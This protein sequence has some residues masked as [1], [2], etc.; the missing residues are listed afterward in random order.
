MVASWEPGTQYNIGDVVEYQGHRYKIIQP[1]R[2]Q[3]DW[4]PDVTPAL[5]GR[6]PDNTWGDEKQGGGGY[7]PSYDQPPA[8]QPY[9][10]SRPPM[11]QQPSGNNWDEH[12]HQKV[13]IP[14]EEQKKNWWD[15]DDDQ[16]KK[17]EIGGGLAVGLAALGA[18]VF[19]YNHHQKS[20]EQKKAAV[21]ALQ[22]WLKEAQARTADF[23][24]H[25]PRGPTTWLLVHGKNFPQNM[26]PGG[27]E[28]GEPLYICRG[29]HDGSIQPGKASATLNTGAVIGYG[30]DEISLE[31]YEVLVGDP[32]AVHW[33]DAHGRLDLN[34]LGARPV[35]GG[36]EAD[37]T[38][39]FIAQAHVHN[40][41]HPGKCSQKLDHAFIPYGGSE[42]EASNYRVLCYH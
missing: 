1:H 3:G 20:E 40:G 6:E 4:T 24:E 30:H 19:A 29:F 17:L 10:E 27:E 41:I 7:Q 21:W 25:G 2:S 12:K 39:L 42:K 38:P 9:V 26:I 35:E 31:A 15:L 22:G 34:A 18:G 16:K 32:R 14:H 37:G 33:V 36:H 23:Y 13:D 5:W 11:E 8:Q 28:N